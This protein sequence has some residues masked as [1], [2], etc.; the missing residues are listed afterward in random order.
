M[1]GDRGM[2]EVKKIDVYFEIAIN[3]P[4]WEWKANDW[5]THSADNLVETTPVM[6]IYFNRISFF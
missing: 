5:E 1:D 4:R 3:S 2:L 6:R